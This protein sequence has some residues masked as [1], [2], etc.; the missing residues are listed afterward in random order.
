MPRTNTR[1]SPY[2]NSVCTAGY[3]WV[4]ME[5]N[6]LLI[7]SSD[8]ECD[9]HTIDV[10]PGVFR[11]FAA[12]EPD[13][14][15]IQRF[16]ASYGDIFNQFPLRRDIRGSWVYGSLLSEWNNE[17]AD[18]RFLVELWDGIT[19]RNARFLRERLVFTLNGGCELVKRWSRN[20]RPWAAR[21]IAASELKPVKFQHNNVYKPALWAL[22]EEINV[23]LA[24]YPIYPELTYIP[25]GNHTIVTFRPTNLLAVMW[26]QFTDAVA[27]KFK[28]KQ[29]E[30]E[31][32]RKYFQ[33]RRA[34]TAKYHSDV[35]RVNA[36][37]ERKSN[38]NRRQ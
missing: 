21:K 26:M 29:C 32:C 2:R 36:W 23:H 24:K 4:E 5:G 31:G 1:T 25:D 33:P 13:P 11:E 10:A 9:R 15:N 6:L 20:S 37:N 28:L 3:K 38:P 34:K 19:N 14:D 18:M 35:C 17:I 7:A 22:R 8:H 16:A 27:G 30:Y 12:L